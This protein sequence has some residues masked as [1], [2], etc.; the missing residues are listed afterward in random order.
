MSEDARNSIYLWIGGIALALCFWA[1][2]KFPVLTFMPRWMN[3]IWLNWVMPAAL[4][5]YGL[6]LL[7]RLV[8]RLLTKRSDANG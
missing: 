6:F 4:L 7:G 5:V 1:F 2:L 3:D 8:L